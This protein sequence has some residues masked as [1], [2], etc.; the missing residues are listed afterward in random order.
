MTAHRFL[1][2]A[3]VISL[4]LAGPS[5]AAG[6][7]QDG[8]ILGASNWQDAEGLLPEEILEHYRRGEYQN[9]VA[10]LD[11]P[12]YIDVSFPPDFQDASGR[13]RGRF[14]L[15]PAGT[16]IEVQTGKQPPYL[17]G[18]PFPDLDADDPRV[19]TKVVWNYFYGTFYN[20]DDHFVNE[21]VMLGRGGV[22]RRVGTD[23]RTRLF[24]G[25]PEA[26]GR[27]NPNNLL[28][29]RFARVIWP[30]DLNGTVSLTWRYR[31]ASKRDSL[32]T[33]VPGIRRP[34]QLSPLNR[35]DGFL[36]SDLSLDDGAFFD[37][38]P[39]DFD[40]RL[41]ERTEQLVLMD[42]WSIR[43]E[44]EILPVAGGGW[45][46]Y[47]K[48]VPRVGADDPNW[49][50]L[51]W[52]PISAVLVRRP[53]WIVEAVAKDPNYLFGRMLL[54]F[55]AETFKGS[56]ASKYDRADFLLVSYQ[57]ASGAYYTMDGGETYVSAGGIAVRI[58]ENFLYDRATVILFPRRDARNP[59]DYHVRHPEIFTID[60]LVRLG[61]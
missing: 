33:Y 27:P 12:G 25:A 28:M 34:R 23:V 35:S 8:D 2:L 11:S 15:S 57:A 5:H 20:G 36:G 21:L 39:E 58:A 45:R 47:W 6:A 60:A 4:W 56:Y 3:L 38:K 19:A 53:V 30:A 54:R 9:G 59:A 41:V 40:F 48:D 42:P 14:D 29:Q 32:W 26:Y 10:D 46:L 50:G 22:E 1:L 31:D 43:G 55:D 37:G 44:A 51:P 52:A 61:K 49:E 16:I 13:N 7:L 24:D 18:L 17:M